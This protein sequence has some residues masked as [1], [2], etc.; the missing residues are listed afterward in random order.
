MTQ[1]LPRQAS[2]TH[3]MQSTGWLD[4][5][6]A[7]PMPRVSAQLASVTARLHRTKSCFCTHPRHPSQSEQ[8]WA[9][10]TLGQGGDTQR[11]P[12]AL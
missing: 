6:Q 9:P 2:W 1:C 3:S 12:Q 10:L 4:Q 5:L 7:S 8:L 11:C